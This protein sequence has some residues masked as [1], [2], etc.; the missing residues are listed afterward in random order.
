M[1]SNIHLIQFVVCLSIFLFLMYVT[2]CLS[3]IVSF[4]IFFPA[5]HFV[6]FPPPFH[7]DGRVQLGKYVSPWEFG[8]TLKNSFNLVANIYDCY[9][10]KIKVNLDT[11]SSLVLQ[12]GFSKTIV[13]NN[14]KCFSFIDNFI[15]QRLFWFTIVC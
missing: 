4:N 1:S 8:N 10:L 11:S 13:L 9:N 14:E 6:F 12:N 15:L 5:F 2:K 7:S 3:F